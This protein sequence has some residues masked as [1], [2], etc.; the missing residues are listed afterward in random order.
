MIIREYSVTYNN[1]KFKAMEEENEP[2][3]NGKNENAYVEDRMYLYISLKD[4][5][6]S[7]KEA[8]E[9]VKKLTDPNK[10]YVNF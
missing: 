1:L 4:K 10:A 5:G 3:G 8:L 7:D 2:F 6:Y 9:E